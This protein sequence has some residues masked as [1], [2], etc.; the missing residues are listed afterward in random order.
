MS[1][2]RGAFV[3]LSPLQGCRTESPLSC[4]EQL[5]PKRAR[6]G[7]GR[8]GGNPGRVLHLT[9]GS[10]L[11]GPQVRRS[12]E[13]S[14]KPGA[15]PGPGEGRRGLLLRTR[16]GHPRAAFRAPNLPCRGGLPGCRGLRPPKTPHFSPLLPR[17]ILLCRQAGPGGVSGARRP[18]GS[19]WPA[20]EQIDL[21][22][23]LLPR[24]SLSSSSCWSF[25]PRTQS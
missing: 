17:Q 25:T 2:F 5:R 14:W 24:L 1:H 8:L 11:L 23:T 6:L 3:G 7:W 18:L 15:F 20:P 19:P 13:R 12:L 10:P 9:R 21:L 22:G 4:G 16:S